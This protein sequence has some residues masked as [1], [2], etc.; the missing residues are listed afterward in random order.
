MP[1]EDSRIPWGLRDTLLVLLG[2]LTAGY[3]AG[4]F[5]H[6]FGLGLPAT[7][8]YLLV[9]LAQAAAILGGLHYFV[10]WKSGLGLAAL[11]LQKEGAGQAL[12]TGLA[13]GLGLFFLVMVVGTFI[14][15]FFPNPTPQPFADLVTQA[16]RPAD[17]LIPLFLG[18][19][20]APLTEELYFRGFLFPALKAR[21]GFVAGLVG[22]SA[23]FGLLHLD[24]MRFLPLALGGMGLAYLYER[25]GNILASITAHATWNTIMILLLYYA[26]RWA[27]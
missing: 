12:A 18:S 11:G 1:E 5:I 15:A 13:G 9:G 10:R 8:R 27:Q 17:L 24:L 3:G 21:Y 25:T 26:L 14:Q 6:F 19:F 4:L 2:L 20:L 7:Y 23:I 22:S 16:R